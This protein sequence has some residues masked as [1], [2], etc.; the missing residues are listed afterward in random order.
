MVVG[1]EASGAKP[2]TNHELTFCTRPTQSVYPV[3]LPTTLLPSKNIPSYHF[4]F[5]AASAVVHLKVNPFSSA[6]YF[7]RRH[8]SLG[9]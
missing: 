4:P 2:R 1:E 9:S 5:S 6:M 7:S 8:N 3:S